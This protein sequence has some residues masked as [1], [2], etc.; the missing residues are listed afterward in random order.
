MFFLATRQ[1]LDRLQQSMLTLIGI[2]LGT[3]AYV[4]FSGIMLGFQDQI[5]DL[6]VNTDA[7]IRISPRD[8]YRTVNAYEGVF[9]PDSEVVWITP[10]SGMNKSSDLSNVYGWY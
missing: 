6:L 9:F 1:L 2:A 5:I 8:E 7:H 10:P 4:M 3:A